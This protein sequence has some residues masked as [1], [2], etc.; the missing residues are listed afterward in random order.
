MSLLLSESLGPRPTR[1]SLGTK[2]RNHFGMH[3][4]QL[5][6]TTLLGINLA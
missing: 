1:P 6:I 3:L 5:K 4:F 2:D